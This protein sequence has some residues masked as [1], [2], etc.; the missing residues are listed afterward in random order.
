MNISNK[1]LISLAIE[2]FAVEF[3]NKLALLTALI[4]SDDYVYGFLLSALGFAGAVLLG[5]VIGALVDTARI[6]RLWF[7]QA[8]TTIMVVLAMI[9]IV[10]ENQHFSYGFIMLLSIVGYTSANIRIAL[11]KRL[12]PKNE[13]TGYHS[14]IVWVFELTPFAVPALCSVLL[15]NSTAV[16]SSVAILV[17]AALMIVS[18][19][20]IRSLTRLSINT[21]SSP[22]GSI[23][24]LANRLRMGTRV[25]R[26]SPIFTYSILV[27]GAINLFVLCMGLLAIV[28]I[29][30]SAPEFGDVSGLLLM[31]VS[32]G[33]LLG[34]LLKNHSWLQKTSAVRQFQLYIALAVAACG[35]MAASETIMVIV[36]SLLFAGFV[37]ALTTVTVWDVRIKNT[38]PNNIGVIAGVTGALYK[39][40]L[41]VI[42]PLVGIVA[43][44]YGAMPGSMMILIILVVVLAASGTISEVQNHSAIDVK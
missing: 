21:D 2:F 35:M 17:L 5:P 13:I 7:A 14:K 3:V 41:L 20:I 6:S 43:E 26:S 1:L 33:A 36:I 32:S 25:I 9:G 30:T 18:A 12:I 10:A 37:S 38:S 23:F 40:P 22:P 16:V 24:D 15:S 11:S 4:K 34:A 31:V 27:A 44:Y 19:F 39:L 42:S 29:K 8:L 28:K